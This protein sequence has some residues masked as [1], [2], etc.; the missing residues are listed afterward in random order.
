MVIMA[1]QKYMLTCFE[2][3]HHTL[4]RAVAISLVDLIYVLIYDMLIH[5][6]LSVRISYGNSK[7][8]VSQSCIMLAKM[9]LV[10]G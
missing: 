5:C 4:P 9:Q 2:N 1:F 6:Q 10:L 7:C 3:E 8:I